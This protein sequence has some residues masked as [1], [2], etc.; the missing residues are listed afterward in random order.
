MI[1]DVKINHKAL[2]LEL[3]KADIKIKRTPLDSNSRTES[4]GVYSVPSAFS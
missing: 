2:R 4:V 3:G 1:K